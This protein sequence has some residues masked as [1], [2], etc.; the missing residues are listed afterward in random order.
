MGMTIGGGGPGK[1]ELMVT[2]VLTFVVFAIIFGIAYKVE[3]ERGKYVCV[4]EKE[5]CYYRSRSSGAGLGLGS[6]G[7]GS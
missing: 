6:T 1:I 5:Y 3:E 4:E 7:D 2:V